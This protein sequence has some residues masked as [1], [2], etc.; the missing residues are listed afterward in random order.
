VEFGLEDG[1][2]APDHEE[3]EVF[4]QATI[5]DA[6]KKVRLCNRN[7]NMFDNNLRRFDYL[8]GRTSDHR[9]K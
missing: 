2:G 6:R 1:L 3:L 9:E 7:D 8:Y 4:W 5:R